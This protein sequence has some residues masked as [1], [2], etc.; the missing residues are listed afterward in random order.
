M[1]GKTNPTVKPVNYKSR[2][3]KSDADIAKEQ[4]DITVK[5]AQNHYEQGVL[6][7]K[8][9]LI[10]KE[11]D[12]SKASVVVEEAKRKLEDAKSLPAC[13]LV[14]GIVNSRTDLKQA[15]LNFEAINTEYQE[16]KEILDYVIEV[17]KELF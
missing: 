8:S 16:L 17:Q 2:I 11:S 14:Q 12:V 1:A 6:S 4:L 10:Q 3:S 15:E 7:L 9:Q 13:E 5:L